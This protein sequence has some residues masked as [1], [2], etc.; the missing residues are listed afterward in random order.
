MIS[1]SVFL[2]KWTG[3]FSA[4]FL[5]IAGVTGS[6][7]AF[8]DE[9][10]ALV[11]PAQVV[12]APRSGDNGQPAPMLDSFELHARAMRALPAYQV[13]GMPLLRAPDR[14]VKLNITRIDPKAPEADQAFVDP[15]DGRLLGVREWGASPFDRT[16]LIGFIY[17]LHYALA[18]PEPWGKWLFGVVALAWTINCLVGIVSTFPRISPFWRRWLPAWLIKPGAN[19]YR[20][21]YDIHR[22]SGLW[23]WG[24]MFLFAW[25]SVTLNLRAEVYTPVMA[26]FLDFQK[27]P[28]RPPKIV[29]KPMLAWR[30]A[31]DVAVKT[32]DDVA[33]AQGF[34]V[35]YPSHLFYNRR[36]DAFV[37]Y[38]N[39]SRDVQQDRGQTGVFIDARNG[40]LLG[41]RIP[42]GE[43]SG[44]TVSRWLQS[45]HMAKVFGLP[46]R[47]FVALIGLA[48]AI[49]A[50]T[51]L[52]VWW[53]KRKARLAREQKLR[54][55][56]A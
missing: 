9:L 47:V 50:Y 53:K 26:R 34:T 56:A 7:L 45:L 21:H 39:T 43:Y 6:L 2:H 44:D 13:I 22:A 37:Y 33:R 16:T 5:I 38:A 4:L 31:Y 17:R 36:F 32:M 14:S 49:S 1:F 35:N 24:V 42:T 3:L 15:Y 11:N 20:L 12:V 48:L 10:D 40:A 52:Y 18:L 23:L 19:T 30:D 25:S 29:G 28:E 46:Y 55:K 51:G 54:L 41:T 27:Q 8:E